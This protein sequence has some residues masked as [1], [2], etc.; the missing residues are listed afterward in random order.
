VVAAARA[1]GAADRALAAALRSDDARVAPED[2]GVAP[3][4]HPGAP[5]G[6]LHERLAE[7]GF[8]ATALADRIEGVQADD[9][10]RTVRTADG[11][12]R[13]LS[14]LDV[15]RAAIDAA[16]GHL[17]AAQSVLTAVV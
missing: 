2:V 17:N 7:L 13:E 10:R 15:V 8:E 16:V 12:G 14:A 5:T 1:I 11:P 9:W 6:T 4:P 3:R